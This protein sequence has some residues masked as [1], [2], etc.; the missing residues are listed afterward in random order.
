MVS[1]NPGSAEQQVGAAFKEKEF[2]LNMSS[3]ANAVVVPEPGS[4]RRHLF[5]SMSWSLC[6]FLAVLTFAVVILPP[7]PIITVICHTGSMG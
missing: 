6:A 5:L 3:T 1:G 4:D 7:I 2:Q